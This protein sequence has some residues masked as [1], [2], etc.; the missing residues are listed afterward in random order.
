M[1]KQ[2]KI[3]ILALL[4]V[5]FFAC[6]S[7]N[8]AVREEA[9]EDVTSKVQPATP[10]Q[11][12]T[13]GAKPAANAV[14]AG[15]TTTIEFKETTYDF[16]T[17]DEGDKVSHTFNFTNTGNEPL[18]F[19]NAKGS[20]GCT[21]PIWPREAIAPGA[22]SEVKVEF[23]SKNK[24]GKRNQKVTLTANTNPPQ[25]FIYLTGNVN[26]AAGGKTQGNPQIQVSQ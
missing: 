5:G 16:G 23:N 21:V 3:G 6:Q 13:P 19:S 9:R 14:P 8:N 1:L 25:T 20:C 11:P 18:I 17:I 4:A 7:G 26:P 2:F 10:N 12:A 24:K 22:T 15:P